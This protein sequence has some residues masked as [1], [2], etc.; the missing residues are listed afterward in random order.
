MKRY[1]GAFG[2]VL[3][4]NDQSGNYILDIGCERSDLDPDRP[5]K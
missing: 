2:E 5:A 1:E 3:I 4:A